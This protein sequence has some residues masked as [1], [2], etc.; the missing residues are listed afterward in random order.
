MLQT[1]YLKEIKIHLCT[2][3]VVGFTDNHAALHVAGVEE[4]V[5]AAGA[6]LLYLPPCCPELNPIKGIFSIVKG[7]LRA[8]DLMFLITADPQETILRAFFHVTRSNVQSLYT[9]CGYL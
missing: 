7:C 9:H 5:E 2:S 1:K 4:I 8:N 3:S 6:I